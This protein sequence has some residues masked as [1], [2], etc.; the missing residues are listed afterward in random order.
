M[1]DINEYVKFFIAVGLFI[2][3]IMMDYHVALVDSNISLDILRDKKHPEY[4]KHKKRAKDGEM[5]LL[6]N[7]ISTLKSSSYLSPDV[8]K[9]SSCMKLCKLYNN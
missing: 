7:C 4:K 8:F 9:N 6:N 5:E 2:F 3:F 1:D